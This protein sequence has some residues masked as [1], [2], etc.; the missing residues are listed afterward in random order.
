MP[1]VGK[2]LSVFH[3][4]SDNRTGRY[5]GRSPALLGKTVTA[6]R[7]YS[8]NQ[9]VGTICAGYDLGRSHSGVPN[10]PVN[11][12]KLANSNSHQRG[13]PYF[14][15]GKTTALTRPGPSMTWV[16]IDENAVSLN[17]AAFGFGMQNPEWIDWPGTYHNNACGIAFADGHSEIVSVSASPSSPNAFP[18]SA[19]KGFGN[20][21][22]GGK[23]W[24]TLRSAGGRRSAPAP[25]P[26]KTSFSGVFPRH[27]KT[28][29]ATLRPDRFSDCE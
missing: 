10:L 28:P 11:G 24:R 18:K 26:K 2:S 9:A 3:C 13:K 29:P 22:G 12:P 15:Y 23:S 25:R 14:T 7:T 4:P 5:T 27:D 21:F 19:D 8:M 6:P 20:I 1:Y 17:D 16:L